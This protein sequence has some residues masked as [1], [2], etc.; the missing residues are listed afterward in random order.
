MINFKKSLDLLL[1]LTGSTD[2]KSVWHQAVVC[3]WGLVMK[4]GLNFLMLHLKMLASMEEKLVPCYKRNRERVT[5]LA[6]SSA[7]GNH[8]LKLELL[9][10]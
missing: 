7:T 2:G 10:K 8:K 4:T 1:V 6:C 5:I 3:L 9:G